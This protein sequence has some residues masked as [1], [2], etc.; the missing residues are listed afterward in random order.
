MCEERTKVR[1]G[2][3]VRRLS[4]TSVRRATA[5]QVQMIPIA[6]A[7][8]KAC[9]IKRQTITY[10]ELV[11]AIGSYNHHSIGRLLDVVWLDCAHRGEPLLTTLVVRKDTGKAAVEFMET[12]TKSQIKSVIHDGLPMLTDYEPGDVSNWEMYL[13]EVYAHWA[14][15]S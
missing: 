2:D 5:H 11:K 14:P 6:R 7:V 12:M 9:A 1:V 8:L 10:G 13:D 15:Q 4:E 3:P